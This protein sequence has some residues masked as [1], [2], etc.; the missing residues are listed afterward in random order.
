MNVDLLVFL[1][2][3][4]KHKHIV[5]SSYSIPKKSILGHSKLHK[6]EARDHTVQRTF[7]QMSAL[8][9]FC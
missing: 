9:R 2:K 4:P 5:N 6:E 8:L 7:S 1:Q 3:V